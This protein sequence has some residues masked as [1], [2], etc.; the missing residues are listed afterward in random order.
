MART[1]AGVLVVLSLLSGGVKAGTAKL[2]GRIIVS[3]GAHER[4]DVP[5]SVRLEG[6]PDPQRPLVL[7]E[8]TGSG[9]VFVPAQLEPGRPP[10]LW[11]ILAGRTPA[12]SRRT[13]ELLEG[14]PPANPARLQM[15]I[16]GGGLEVFCGER[17]ILRYNASFVQLPQGVGERFLRSG[18]IHPVLAPSGAL[19]TD[20]FPPDHRHHKGVWLAWTKT[21]FEGRHPD[22]WNLGD[23]TGTVRFAGFEGLA[24]GPVYVGFAARHEHIDLSS[25]DRKSALIERW[26]VRVWDVGETF[27]LW[28][29]ESRQTCATASPLVLPE[30]RYGGIGLRGSREWTVERCRFLTSEG[31]TRKDGHGTRARWCDISGLVGKA[32]AGVLVMGHPANFRFPEPM[33]IH[34]DIPFFNFAPSQAGDWVIEPGRE[35]VFR[36]RFCVHD[37]ELEP[38]EA[39][40]L[41]RDFAEPPEAKFEPTEGTRK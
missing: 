21:V 8:L 29:L 14:G 34:P 16:D 24:N 2:L 9:R 18:Y 19:V 27:W 12:G 6:L 35:Y 36:Y 25:P 37:G 31:K 22:F 1:A 4:R 20:D 40:R 11:W 3:S 13:Y 33:R 23:G 38:A 32:W 30:Y 41:W 26:D 28:E 5:V 7:E 39:E 17:R 10:R 15:R